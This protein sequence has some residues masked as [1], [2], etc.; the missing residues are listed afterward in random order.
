MRVERT[1]PDETRLTWGFDRTAVGF[2]VEVRRP[3]SKARC[4]DGLQPSYDRHRPLLGLLDF[5][6]ET[7]VIST[8]DRDEVLLGELDPDGGS[9]AAALAQEILDELRR[10]AAD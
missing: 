6:V 5:L 8:D 4:Y 2:F 1:L 9:A 3:R 10:F 7:E